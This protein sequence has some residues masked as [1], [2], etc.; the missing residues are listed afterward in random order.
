M[1]ESVA[2]E[3]RRPLKQVKIEPGLITHQTGTGSVRIT[4]QRKVSKLITLTYPPQ[5]WSIP[6]P[7]ENYGYLLD[8]SQST[9]SWT[10]NGH[11]MTMA[12]IIK[13]E[14]CH[15]LYSMNSPTH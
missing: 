7:G 14:V 6:H 5:C 13:A 9:Q 11:R 12:A 10:R 2:R 4:R 15:C 1:G 8:L 3:E